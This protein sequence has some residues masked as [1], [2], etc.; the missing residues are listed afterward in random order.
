MNYSNPQAQWH[1][2]GT[3]A[4]SSSVYENGTA[5]ST[6]PY[7]IMKRLEQENLRLRQQVSEANEGIFDLRM[8]MAETEAVLLHEK[9]KEIEEFKSELK[10]RVSS[11]T[12]I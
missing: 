8:Q 1:A 12:F 4:T 3:Q 11:I 10:F 7:E 2:F 9:A 6:D 5:N